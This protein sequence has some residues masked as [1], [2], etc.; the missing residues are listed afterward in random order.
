MVLQIFLGHGEF[1]F[2][3]DMILGAKGSSAGARTLNT[4]DSL[5]VGLWALEASMNTSAAATVV[6][7][8]LVGCCD[9]A[10]NIG[11]SCLHQIIVN[12]WQLTELCLEHT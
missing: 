8:P 11:S 9:L 5:E 6:A 3:C 12:I 2:I 1:G 4:S 10:W 7:L